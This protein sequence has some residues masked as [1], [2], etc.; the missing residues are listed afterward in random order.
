M[1]LINEA[2]YYFNFS[3]ICKILWRIELLNKK[4]AVLLIKFVVTLKFQFFQKVN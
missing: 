3:N 2:K 1:Q 4:K